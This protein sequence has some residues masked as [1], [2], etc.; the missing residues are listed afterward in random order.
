MASITDH[1]LISC[2][3]ENAPSLSFWLRS[4]VRN[5]RPLRS[6]AAITVLRSVKTGASSNMGKIWKMMHQTSGSI[7]ASQPSVWNLWFCAGWSGA[8]EVKSQIK[9][10]KKQGPPYL[11]NW[12]LSVFVMCY[13]W[14]EILAYCVLFCKNSMWNFYA[15]INC[16]SMLY[17]CHM[18][19]CC[20]TFHYL[21][22][23]K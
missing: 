14:N 22:K 8:V 19:S 9:G 11:R 12:P 3:K 16:Y 21:K 18:T 13:A 2:E 5:S 20:C 7:P 15:T 1:S 23:K 6:S 4:W 17:C 10:S